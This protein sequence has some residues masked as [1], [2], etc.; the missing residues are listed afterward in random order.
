MKSLLISHPDCA[1]H[2]MDGHPERPERLAAVMDRLE[3]SG[4]VKD[5]EQISAREIS[6][7][8]LS[9]AHSADYVNT[10][11]TSEV[12]NEVVRLDPDTFLGPGSLRA[13]KLAAGAVVQ[14]TEQVIQGITKRAFCAIRPPGHHAELAAAM[15]FCI[16]NNIA[17]A[18]RV[19]LE[20][21]AIKTV[22]I[23]DFDVH[24]CNGTVDIF[25]D[26]ERVLVCSSFQNQF[27]PHRY[28]DFTNEHI[29][30][31]PLEPGTEGLSFRHSI[32]NSWLAKLQEH[33]P[34]II[35]ISAGF[36]AH[37]DDPLAEICLLEDDYRWITGMITDLAENYSQGRIVSTLEGGYNL[38]S[39]ASSALAHVERLCE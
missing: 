32:E 12:Q 1:R 7:S 38:E 22:A 19:A 39:L 23:C 3:S 35:F 36:D 21:P 10:V 31:T 14:A 6:S 26:D 18:T 34:D 13:A 27:Y 29:V 28:L 37:R 8:Q 4:L 16:F 11:E 9:L 15:G 20:N 17:V 30:N 5:M 33:K 24:H 25:K 2:A